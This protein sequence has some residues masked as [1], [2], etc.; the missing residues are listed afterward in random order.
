MRPFNLSTPVY[1]FRTVSFWLRSNISAALFFLPAY[2][3]PP[4][5]TARSE[6]LNQSSLDQH[7]WTASRHKASLERVRADWCLAHGLISSCCSWACILM[8]HG[9][10]RQVMPSLHGVGKRLVIAPETVIYTFNLPDSVTVWR[11]SGIAFG[12]LWVGSSVWE[13]IRARKW[14]SCYVCD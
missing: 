10:K 13:V 2:P 12:G 6:A 5:V 8:W 11:C 1:S 4:S 7:Y 14:G 3:I 9:S